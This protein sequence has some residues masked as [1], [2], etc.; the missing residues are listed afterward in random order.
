[1]RIIMSKLSKSKISKLKLLLDSILKHSLRIQEIDKQ[2][3][4][5]KSR[6]KYTERIA[7]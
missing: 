7:G 4:Y 3:E 1:M 6:K 2:I 5:F